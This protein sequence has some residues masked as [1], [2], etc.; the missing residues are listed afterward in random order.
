MKATLAKDIV[1]DALLMAVWRRRPNEPVIIHS[2]AQQWRLAEFSQ[3]YN[4]VPSNEP[5][6]PCTVYCSW[7]NAVTESFFSSLKKERIK[8]RIHKRLLPT[9][10]IFCSINT[11]KPASWGGCR[12]KTSRLFLWRNQSILIY[13]V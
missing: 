7:D 11:K 4:L 12:L 1:L 9:C 8:K 10:S 6:R 13:L 5:Q 3:K 2:L